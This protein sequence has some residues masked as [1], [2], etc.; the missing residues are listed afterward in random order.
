MWLRLRRWA[1]PRA[2]RVVALTA[3]T[4]DWIERHVPGSKVTVIPNA[5]RWPLEATE[6]ILAPPDKGSRHR[7]LAVGR[8]HPVKGFDLL[9]R[10][11]QAIAD[12][13]PDWD[14]VILGEGEGRSELQ[15]QID[16]AG[17]SARISMPG[18]AGNIGQWYEASDLYVLSSRI[19][20]L[21]N[22][23]LESMASGLAPVAFD[24]ETGPREIVRNGIDG[25]LVNPP[26]DDEALAAYLSDMMAHHEQR[27]AYARRAVDVRDRFSTA[28]IMA[29]W[30]Q[31]FEDS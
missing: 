10:A 12:Y 3:G 27:E 26:E 30:R 9:I 5:V 22:S 13:F 18:R 15:E 21:S 14:L 29:L 7:L 19:E 16:A 23:L 6:P 31:V 25:V 24:C 11:F 1:Y 2:S 20:G 17:L 8:L 28:R 4:A